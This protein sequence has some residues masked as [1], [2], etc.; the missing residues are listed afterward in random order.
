MSEPIRIAIVED[1]AG[2]RD[3]LQQVFGKAEDFQ[4]VGAFGDGRQRS[5]NCRW[6]VRAWC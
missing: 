4:V 3:T 5:T 1:D 2:L 6:W